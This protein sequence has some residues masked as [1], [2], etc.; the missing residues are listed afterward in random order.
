MVNNVIIKSYCS[1]GI[2]KGKNV[3]KVLRDQVVFTPTHKLNLFLEVSDP[4]VDLS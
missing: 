4:W 2:T 3:Q 1:K